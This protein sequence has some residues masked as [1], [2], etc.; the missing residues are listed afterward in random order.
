V[1]LDPDVV[2]VPGATE[3]G[4]AADDDELPPSPSAAVLDVAFLA[5]AFFAG[6]FRADRDEPEDADV[7]AGPP[8]P[9]PPA[10]VG[11]ERRG[12]DVC[13][14]AFVEAA[15]VGVAF[16][17]V[18][19]VGVAFFAVVLLA[20]V[21]LAVVFLAVVFL[22]AGFV[23]VDVFA[24]DVFAG[25]RVAVRDV[26]PRA[27]VLFDELLFTGLF[28]AAAGR[29]DALLAVLLDAARALS[30]AVVTTSP[31]PEVVSRTSWTG[32][33]TASEDLVGD[34]RVPRP[35]AARASSSTWPASDVTV[36][37]RCWTSPT[38][39][40][41]S[42]RPIAESTSRRTRRT[43]CL[44]FVS[45][46]VNRS[47]ASWL[48]CLATFLLEASAPERVSSSRAASLARLRVSSPS[49]DASSTYPWMERLAM[50]PPRCQR[51]R[52]AVRAGHATRVPRD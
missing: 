24:V 17:G 38:R 21:F 44:R 15:F 43:S 28:L 7:L 20:V 11:P 47:S 25:D 45:A 30:E 18:A 35:L 39:R 41:T 48:A 51:P 12:A 40:D 5:G 19:F 36:A 9:E 32:G 34:P 29:P 52:S 16:V 8:E 4:P 49:P 33:L 10:V 23:A 2:G 13:P 26:P 42:R 27:A 1:S 46:A 50:D 6:A 22:A 37:P 31:A 3:A 14:V